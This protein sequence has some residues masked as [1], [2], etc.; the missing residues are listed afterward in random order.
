M[1]HYIPAFA[2][3]WGVRERAICGDYVFSADHA[4]EPTCP[5]CKGLISDEEKASATV[6]ISEVVERH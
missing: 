3:V 1:T 2:A 5:R 6:D 4:L